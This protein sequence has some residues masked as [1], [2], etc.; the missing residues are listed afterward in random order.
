MATLSK[1]LEMEAV[2]SECVLSGSSWKIQ[3]LAIFE[4]PARLSRP[5]ITH[6]HECQRISPSHLDGPLC[7]AAGDH[8]PRPATSTALG[9]VD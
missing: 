8:A 5:P 6:L 4:R 7:E 9:L 2:T 3:Q 1:R